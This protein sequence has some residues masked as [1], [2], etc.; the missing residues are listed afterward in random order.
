LIAA[1]A[2]KFAKVIGLMAIAGGAA[3]V[4]FFGGR[5]ARVDNANDT[6]KQA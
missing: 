4:K 1:F 5:K 6:D 3:F 2:A